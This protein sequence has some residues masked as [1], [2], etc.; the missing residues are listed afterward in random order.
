MKWIVE[1][2]KESVYEGAEHTNFVRA[3]VAEEL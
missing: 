1:S 2:F 3:S